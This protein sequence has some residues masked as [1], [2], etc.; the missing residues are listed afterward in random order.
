LHDNATAYVL[1]EIKEKFSSYKN[2][3]TGT[4]LITGRTA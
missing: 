3:G 4:S 2:I 1:P